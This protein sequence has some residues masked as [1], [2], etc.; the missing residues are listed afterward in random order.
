[1]SMWTVR[2][3]IPSISLFLDL[4]NVAYYYN[5]ELS[6]SNQGYR[7]P[8]FILKDQILWEHL[9]KLQKIKIGLFHDKNPSPRYAEPHIPGKGIFYALAL[10]KYRC[11][12]LKI[13]GLGPAPARQRILYTQISRTRASSCSAAYTVYSKCRGT[14]LL[15]LCSVYCILKKPEP[16]LVSARQR[17]LVYSKCQGPGWF[18]LDS[19]YLYTQI[20]WA[21]SCSAAYTV[22]SNFQNPGL[23]LF[24]SVYC[25]PRLVSV[26]Q[27][28]LYTQISWPAPALQRI[29]YTQISRTRACSYSAAYTVYSNFQNPGLFLFCSVYLYTQ[30]S[31][32]VPARQRILYTQNARVRAG[33]YSIAYTC[34][35]KMP[36]SGL[37]STL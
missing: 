27:R 32:P 7:K 8:D 22:Y 23:F 33:F 25:E 1:M 34:I 29:L 17:I 36:G 4:L 12:I 14:G 30:I 10:V 20:S 31:W 19:V 26:L 24:G 9:E 13:P 21:A 6:T 28:I 2:R 11:C 35:L 5:T 18:L 3:A 16:G 37:V 15:L